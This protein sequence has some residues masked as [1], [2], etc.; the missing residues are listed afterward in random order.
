MYSQCTLNRGSRE[1]FTALRLSF[2]DLIILTMTLPCTGRRPRNGRVQGI[3]LLIACV[4]MGV[5]GVG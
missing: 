2:R 1:L 3:D 4:E 5:S